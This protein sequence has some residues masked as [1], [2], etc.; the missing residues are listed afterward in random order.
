MNKYL[1]ES[2]S[3]DMD[4][5]LVVRKRPIEKIQSEKKYQINL[6]FLKMLVC[7][8][9]V[10][11]QCRRCLFPHLSP[12][13]FQPIGQQGDRWN[14]SK[15][16]SKNTRMFGCVF[17]WM[18]ITQP[19]MTST[20]FSNFSQKGWTMD[21]LQLRRCSF[22]SVEFHPSQRWFFLQMVDMSKDSYSKSKN[23]SQLSILVRS[24]SHILCW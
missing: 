10:L 8:P 1:N 12:N 21:L 5:I 11:G 14:S 22:S 7:L 9:F 6:Y 15:S 23:R 4:C 18:E 16:W 24:C 20:S 2:L 3:K 13:P 17:S 19:S